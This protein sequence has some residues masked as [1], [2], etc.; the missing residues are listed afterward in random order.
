MLEAKG[1]A[2]KEAFSVNDKITLILSHFIKFK[3]A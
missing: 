2:Q 3:L 1:L